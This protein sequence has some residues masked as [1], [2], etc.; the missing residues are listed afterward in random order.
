M[1]S[2]VLRTLV[3]ASCLFCT[4][5]MAE[6]CPSEVRVVF[7]NFP[8]APYIYGT[9]AI[10]AP[11]GKLVEWSQAALSHTGCSPKVSFF[12]RPPRRELAELRAGAYD[13]APGVAFTP[14][15]L[16]DFAFPMRS[17][18]I[19]QNLV[20]VRDRVSLYVRAGDESVKWDGKTLQLPNPIVGVSAGVLL[21]HATAER[22]GWNVES[23]YD[24]QGNLQKL[25]AN[26]VDVILEPDI[27]LLSFMTKPEG[28]AI[29]KL[30]PPAM[31][32][33]RY[34][35]VSK[36]FQ[37]KYPEFTRRFWLE[38]CKESRSMSP[39]LPACRM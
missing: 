37:Q 17:G 9:D 20:I 10:V 14:E 5:A 2:A 24:P 7:P 28:K 26:R 34:A 29:R 27:L 1:N 18:A 19:N 11:P 36:Q 6:D 38:I 3:C 23:A 4:L 32:A 12:R 16:H 30:I 25:M 39:T 33:D 21:A 31:E 13:I 22:N 15:Q 35:P 8:V